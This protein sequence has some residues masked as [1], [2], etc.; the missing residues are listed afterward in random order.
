MHTNIIAHCMTNNVLVHGC[1]VRNKCDL[2]SALKLAGTEKPLAHYSVLRGST[3]HIRDAAKIN[4]SS[5]GSLGQTTDVDRASLKEGRDTIIHERYLNF[6]TN[7][8]NWGFHFLCQK[9]G[10]NLQRDIDHKPFPSF[11]LKLAA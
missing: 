11:C 1:Q 3:G 6:E 4:K 2:K 7:G 5:I 8:D 9:L 10:L